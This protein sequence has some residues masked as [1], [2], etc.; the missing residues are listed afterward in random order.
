MSESADVLHP[1]QLQRAAVRGS[2]VRLESTWADIC[3][4]ANYAPPLLKLLGESLAASALFASTIKFEGSLSIQLRTQGALRLLFAECSHDGRLRGIARWEGEETPAAIP[5]EGVDA[6]LAITIENAQTETRYQGLVPVEGERLAQAFEGYFEH[7]E[8]L[9]TRIVLAQAGGRC[10]GIM[11]QQVAQGGGSE[12]SVDP[13]GWNRVD[14]LLATLTDEEL[15]ELPVE[16]LL[17]RLFHEEDVVLQPGRP[18]AFECTCSRERVAT[19][20]RSLG[21]EEAG[22]A[23]GEEAEIAI[24]CEFCNRDYRLDRVDIAQLFANGPAVPEP[25][26]PQ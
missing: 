26:T 17:L 3:S 4:H 25:P 19:M 20:L 21:A 14:H 12:T 13:D 6:Q 22:A 10:A 15:L 2:L 7:S 9:P 24:T 5:L 16:T 8:Q 18:Q 1:F 23:L 11:L